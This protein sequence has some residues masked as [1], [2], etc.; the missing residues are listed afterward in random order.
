AVPAKKRIISWYGPA[1]RVEYLQEKF[2]WMSEHPAHTYKLV[3]T[4][5]TPAGL[6]SLTLL[7]SLQRSDVVSFCEGPS[8]FWSRLVA[9]MFG[10]TLVYAS[11][12]KTSVTAEPDIQ[13]VISDYGLP[14]VYPLCKLYGIVGD[15][16]FQ[17]RSPRLHNIAYRKLG[18]PALFVPFQAE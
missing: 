2:K 13:Q 5:S 7:K 9:P 6:T 11:S 8:G 12:E 17:S 3:I 10:A 1:A 14:R 16:V 18:V 15:P 4:G